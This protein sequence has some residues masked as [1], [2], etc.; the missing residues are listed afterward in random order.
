MIYGPLKYSLKVWLTSVLASPVLFT[1]ILCVRQLTDISDIL[2]RGI[3]IVSMYIFL[4]IGQLLF[5]I[6][7]WLAFLLLI[8]IIKRFKIQECLRTTLIFVTGIILIVGTFYLMLAPFDL[9]LDD[10]AN[11]MYANCIGIGWG[12]WYYKLT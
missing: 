4:V 7:T 2:S 8:I 5:S 3:G 11:L 12:V 6:I 9:L 10:L 1:L